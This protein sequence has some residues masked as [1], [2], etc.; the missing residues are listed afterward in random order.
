MGITGLY[1]IIMGV[2]F[3][4]FAIFYWCRDKSHVLPTLKGM[5]YTRRGALEAGVYGATLKFVH[6]IAKGAYIPGD[7]ADNTHVEK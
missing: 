4:P 2:L 7:E 3:H 6:H 1:N 5:C